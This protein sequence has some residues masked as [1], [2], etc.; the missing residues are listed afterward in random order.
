MTT[1]VFFFK[2]GFRNALSEKKVEEAKPEVIEPVKEEAVEEEPKEEVPQETEHRDKR[3]KK[4]AVEE[5][6]EDDLER[7]EGA[8]SVAEYKELLKQKN[9]GLNNGA[10]KVVKANETEANIVTRE[11]KKYE[12]GVSSVENKKKEIKK[13]EKKTD[14]KDVIV[15]LKTDDGRGEKKN[16]G[17]KTKQGGKF[18]FSA[19]DFPEL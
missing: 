18:N 5:K 16:Y 9:Q 1:N 2:L 11:D 13:K 19:N 7:P 14:V 15:E 6:Q 10:K 17:G 3:K 4:G 8:L 12:L